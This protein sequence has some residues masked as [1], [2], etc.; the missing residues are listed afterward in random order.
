MTGA[1]KADGAFE[2]G[3]STKLDVPMLPMPNPVIV[4]IPDWLIVPIPVVPMLPMPDVV[5]LPMPDTGPSLDPIP[6][7][8]EVGG[9]TKPVGNGRPCRAV[10]V[11]TGPGTDC[12]MA[13][14]HRLGGARRT[15]F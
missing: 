10:P 8:P 3:G 9:L 14:A 4:P 5:M 12:T 2:A 11:A 7:P 13:G 1:A 15:P 6:D